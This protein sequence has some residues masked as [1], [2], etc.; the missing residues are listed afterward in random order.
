MSD[1]LFFTVIFTGYLLCARTCAKCFVKPHNDSVRSCWLYF[2]DEAI[3]D[4]EAA[5]V[6][7]V[8]K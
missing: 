1:F 2:T 8:A 6:H 4:R 7:V 3:E 5:Q